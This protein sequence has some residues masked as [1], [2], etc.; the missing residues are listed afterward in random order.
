[1]VAFDI[2][3]L[4]V[5]NGN[6]SELNDGVVSRLIS[7]AAILR[8]VSKNVPFENKNFYKHFC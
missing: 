1:M 6:R 3:R 2:D 4:G 7:V 8:E 5:I